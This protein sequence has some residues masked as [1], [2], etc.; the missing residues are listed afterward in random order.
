MT[1]NGHYMCQVNIHLLFIF[2]ANHVDQINTEPMVSQIGMLSVVEAPDILYNQV[3]KKNIYKKSDNDDDS[4]DSD[5]DDDD[6]RLQNHNDF[7]RQATTQSQW[8]EQAPC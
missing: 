7:F 2:I 4:H 6:E 8:K 1:Q 3:L 5:G